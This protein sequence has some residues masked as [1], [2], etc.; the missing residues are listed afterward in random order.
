MEDAVAMR[1]SQR[2]TLIAVVLGFGAVA[3]LLVGLGYHR[4]VVACYDSRHSIDREPMVGEGPIGVALDALLW[5]VFVAATPADV[6]C[7]PRPLGE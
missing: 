1:T 6:S 7:L 4:L 5:P 2:L 3:Y